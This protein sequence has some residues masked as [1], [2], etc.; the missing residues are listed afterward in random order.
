MAEAI[1]YH[2]LTDGM[3]MEDEIVRL[4]L[5][6]QLTHFRQ[7]GDE[8]DL[9]RVAYPLDKVLLLIICTCDDFEDIVEWGETC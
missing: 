6:A 1:T 9:W 3:D 2:I 7:V 4:R 5:V 8:R